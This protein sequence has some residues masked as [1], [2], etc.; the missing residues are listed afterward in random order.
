M[1]RVDPQEHFLDYGYNKRNSEI[2]HFY[3]KKR[4]PSSFSGSFFNRRRI[5]FESGAFQSTF[6]NA[7]FFLPS[8][9]DRIE[10]TKRHFGF[11]N[12]LPIYIP[13]KTFELEEG[14]SLDPS[15]LDTE[16]TEKEKITRAAIKMFKK[17]QIYRMLIWL[18]KR[19]DS[20]QQRMLMTRLNGQ[21]KTKSVCLIIDIKCLIDKCFQLLKNGKVAR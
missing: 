7:Y 12:L 18:R 2:L 9:T 5:Q 10:E 15:K 6:S 20:S 13:K 11:V 4:I 16:C 3:Y 1:V 14:I 21:E 8:I 19:V 17:S